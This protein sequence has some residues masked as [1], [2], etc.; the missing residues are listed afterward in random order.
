MTTHTLAEE[1]LREWLAVSGTSQSELA[2]TIGVTRAAVSKWASGGARPSENHA[3][4]I[5]KLSQGAVPATIW[6]RRRPPEPVNKG[7]ATIQ[8]AAKRYNGS[9]AQLARETGLPQRGLARW[10]AGQNGPRQST[11][12]ALNAALQTNLKVS[13]F[14]VDA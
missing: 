10:A 8:K 13:D 6:P 14:W 4:E 5:D 1:C 11:L 7:A 3:E 12:A 9:I 2:E